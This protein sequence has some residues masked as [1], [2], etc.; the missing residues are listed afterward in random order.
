M[1]CKSC[2]MELPPDASPNAS[3]TCA[4]MAGD[5]Q[6][7]MGSDGIAWESFDRGLTWTKV[8]QSAEKDGPVSDR[9]AKQ[10]GQKPQIWFGR[11]WGNGDGIWFAGL[12]T[13][14]LGAGLSPVGAY[15]DWIGVM[16]RYGPL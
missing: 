5:Y 13:G 3:Q 4:T 1:K 15:W 12:K 10:V 16:E 11:M 8:G 2:G 6:A 7:Q 9:A 14:H